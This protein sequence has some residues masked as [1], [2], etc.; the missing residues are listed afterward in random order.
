ME[1]HE[2]RIA[3]EEAAKSAAQNDAALNVQ[4]QSDGN[5]ADGQP[6]SMT[7]RRR[8]AVIDVTTPAPTTPA[9]EEAPSE[10]FFPNDAAPD[11]V[12]RAP[13]L[14]EQSAAQP[15]SQA[16]PPSSAPETSFWRRLFS[17]GSD[18]PDIS[19]ERASESAAFADFGDDYSDT[20]QVSPVEPTAFG[21]TD[22]GD[23]TPSVQR[24]PDTTPRTRSGQPEIQRKTSHPRPD[25]LPETP[26]IAPAEF[27]AELPAGAQIAP[28]TATAPHSVQ[29]QTSEPAARSTPT[30]IQRSAVQ[31]ETA[32]QPDYRAADYPAAS[33]APQATSQPTPST[34]AAQRDVDQTSQPST[35]QPAPRIQRETSQPTIQRQVEP[36]SYHELPSLDDEAAQP[37][38]SS[39]SSSPEATSGQTTQPPPS[40]VQRQTDASPSISASTPAST[41]R[42][43]GGSSDPT[44]PAIQRAVDPSAAPPSA[45]APSIQRETSQ[46]TIQRQVEPE[47]RDELP[48]LDDEAVQPP[49]SSTSSSPEAT[50]GQT[51]QPPPPPVQRQ[52]SK[53][54]SQQS[55]PNI[56]RETSQPPA[57]PTFTGDVR[58]S[59]TDQPGRTPSEAA[60]RQI[61]RSPDTTAQ[62]A[63]A[64]PRLERTPNPDVPDVPTTVTRTPEIQSPAG[65]QR[66]ASQPP[67]ENLSAGPTEPNSSGADAPTMLTPAAPQ[68]PASQPPAVQHQTSAEPTPDVQRETRVPG[69]PPSPWTEFMHPSEKKPERIKRPT[70][71]PVQRTSESPDTPL[72]S[73]DPGQTSS[74]APETVYRAVDDELP[75]PGEQ[76]VDLFTAMMDVGAVA[77]PPPSATLPQ[78]SR[79]AAPESQTPSVQSP[80]DRQL[81]SGS[82]LE[83]IVPDAG[84]TEAN[85]LSLIDLPPNTPIIR[86]AQSETPAARSITPAPEHGVS[87]PPRRPAPPTTFSPLTGEQDGDEWGTIMRASAP[88]ATPSAPSSTASTSPD[89]TTGEGTQ[90][91]S[92]V[93]V[94]KLAR[95]VLD[96]LRRRLRTEQERR[97]GKL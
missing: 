88:E 29:R 83:Q 23:A 46:P 95:D 74:D 82:G 42:E 73:T 94:D 71:P 77:S 24:K 51:T 89:T 27:S 6:R 75:S 38:I 66:K 62:P 58:S 70:P 85:L 20:Q 16:A 19:T 84:S 5:D 40:P 97:G 26:A 48:S 13:E 37:P 90:E 15:D 41:R 60:P 50:S 69:I 45:S 39:T 34:P 92:E 59:P 4:R 78:I 67:A 18:T 7:R 35:R 53:A 36:E 32:V 76:A 68:A 54:S 93:D 8:G 22:V 43:G 91:E 65:V 86:R 56:Q 28:P 30:E 96:V 11:D 21:T 61:Q 64:A 81:A 63:P 47:S 17:R 57:E 79:S 44:L 14:P 80:T 72:E 2:E 31:P 55:A 12:Q 10:F 87:Q 25:S 49:I 33:V 52:V 9:S 3:R 1:A